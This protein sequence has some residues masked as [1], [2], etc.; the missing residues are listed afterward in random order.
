MRTIGL[1]YATIL[2]KCSTNGPQVLLYRLTFR[3]ALGVSLRGGKDS[4]IHKFYSY[5]IG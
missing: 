4:K 2:C 5:L 1:Q 3:D